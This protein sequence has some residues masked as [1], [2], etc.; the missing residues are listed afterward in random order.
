MPPLPVPDRLLPLLDGRTLG[1]L[2]TISQAGQPQVNPVWFL[3]ENDC[4]LLS[5]KPET[6]KYR[7]LRGN[8]EAA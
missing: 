1:H 5:V 2:A 7:N 8:P 6:V 4:L 3:W